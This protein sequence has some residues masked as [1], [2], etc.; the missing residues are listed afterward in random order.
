ME[1]GLTSLRAHL[2]HISAASLDVLFLSKS[3]GLLSLVV[4]ILSSLD[5]NLRNPPQKAL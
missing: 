4:L 1:V 3:G 5:A 2:H